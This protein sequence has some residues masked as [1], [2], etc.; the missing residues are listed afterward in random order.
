MSFDVFNPEA[1]GVPRGWNNGMLGPAGGRVLFVAGQI[2]TDGA[3]AIAGP[4]MAQQ[5]EKALSNVAAVVAAAGGEVAD[6][7][8]LTIYV[9]NMDEYRGSLK[10]IGAG[11]RAVMGRHFPAMA[12]V[13]VTSLVNPEATIEVEATAVIPAG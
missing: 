13:A 3:G 5:F 8:R 6:I 7:G 10:D 2:G 12:L 4:T 9:T 11:Y 1:L